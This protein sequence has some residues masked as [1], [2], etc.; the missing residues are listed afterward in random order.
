MAKDHRGQADPPMKNGRPSRRSVLIHVTVRG[1]IWL[2][3]RQSRRSLIHA[4]VRGTIW[5]AEFTH[6]IVAHA[7]QKHAIE[8]GVL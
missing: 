3:G 8:D 6:G 1:T 2:A 5:T 4:T 7:C